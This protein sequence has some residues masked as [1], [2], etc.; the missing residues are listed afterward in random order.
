[1]PARIHAPVGSAPATAA[2][3]GTAVAPTA[4]TASI[5]IVQPR[6]S[7]TAPRRPA[8]SSSAVKRLSA[9]GSPAAA[10]TASESA[11]KAMKVWR[12]KSS[13]PRP[14]GDDH[15]QGDELQ[16][17]DEVADEVP[18]PAAHDGRSRRDPQLVAGPSHGRTVPYDRRLD[19]RARCCRH[20]SARVVVPSSGGRRPPRRSPRSSGVP[21]WLRPTSRSCSSGRPP[22]RHRPPCGGRSSASCRPVPRM[23]AT[24]ASLDRGPNCW[25]SWT[26]TS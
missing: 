18:C 11:T 3:T 17:R 14:R 6:S 10:A 5:R 15:R 8:P 16:L 9:A 13:G 1:M 20:A 4:A 19:G 26:M 7:R 23:P 25:H 12:P 22:V 21:R 2:T 24:S